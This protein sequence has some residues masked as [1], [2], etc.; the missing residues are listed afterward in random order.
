MP[1]SAKKRDLPTSPKCDACGRRLV[2][3]PTG[4]GR[5]ARFCSP[6]CRTAYH[7]GKRPPAE[8]A[9]TLEDLLDTL[10]EL[11]EGYEH[12]FSRELA[13]IRNILREH[14]SRK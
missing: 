1:T 8:N 3:D 13:T 9:P 7:R 4:K 6:T 14:F 11:S 2:I 5:V 12:T 10:A